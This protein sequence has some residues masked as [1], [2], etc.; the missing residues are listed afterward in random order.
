VR[1]SSRRSWH[2]T[3]RCS[4]RACQCPHPAYGKRQQRVRLVKL[5]RDHQDSQGGFPTTTFCHMPIQRAIM[6]VSSN[7]AERTHVPSRRALSLAQDHAASQ[8][9]PLP[10]PHRRNWHD[11]AGLAVKDNLARAVGMVLTTGSPAAP[12]SIITSQAP[13]I[14]GMA[15]TVASYIAR[16]DRMGNGP[17]GTLRCQPQR[18]YLVGRVVLALLRQQ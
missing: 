14:A 1:V 12:A 2:K 10:S 17:A 18:G 13:R 16:A 5:L 3:C 15:Y 7:S 4:T 6:R 8:A 11:D 9:M